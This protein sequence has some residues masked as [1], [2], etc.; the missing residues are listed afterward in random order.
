MEIISVAKGY[1]C[2]PSSIIETENSYL[3][4]CFDRACLWIE[5]QVQDKKKLYFP[6]DA[7]KN[8]EQN[9][10]QMNALLAQTGLFNNLK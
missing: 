5:Q 2:R 8:R 10:Q 3:A 6:E 9:K 7:K 4:F 1:N